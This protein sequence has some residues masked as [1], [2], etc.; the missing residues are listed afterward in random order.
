[1]GAAAGVNLLLGMVRVKFVAILIGTAGTGLLASFTS[2]QTLVTNICGF[3]V[4]SSA[5]RTLAAA[6]ALEDEDAI[7]RAALALHR[8]SWVTGL[9]GMAALAALSPLISDVTFRS[10]QYAPEIGA[11]GLVVLFTNLSGAQMALIQGMRR[12]GDIARVNLLAALCGTVNA[13][14]LYAAFGMRGIVPALIS[15]AAFQLA[16]S[17]H[18]ARRVPIAKVIVPWS[19][20]IRDAGG[21]VRLG[22]VFMWTG[23][24]ASGVNYVT[25]TFIT[26]QFGLHGAGLFSA[27]FALSGVVINFI[28]AAMG[29]DYYPRLTGA[30][31]ESALFR[32]LVNEQTEVGVLL[33]LPGLIATMTLAPWVIR[34]FYTSEFV[35]AVTLLHW[36]ILGCFGRVVAWPLGF[37]MPALGKDKWFLISETGGHLL[38]LALVLAGL[39]LFG[40]TGVAVAFFVVYL[41]YTIAVLSIA[42]HLVGFRWSRESALLIAYSCATLLGCFIA[43]NVLDLWPATLAGIAATLA[44]SVHNLRQLA[45]RL[46]PDHRLA[47]IARSVLAAVRVRGCNG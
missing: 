6:V 36:F 4:Q 27:G 21:M 35:P 45:K 5:V 17:W 1:M 46:E 28:L 29:A 32:Q 2:V 11:L 39:H 24:L 40:L 15:A 34:L 7:A 33:A 12:I 10:G 31:H 22:L 30:A 18:F 43:V 37:V 16:F 25:V 14:V 8:L 9:V 41:A 42:R 20:S 3:G 26:Q 38:H 19:E 47:R 23:L 44:V 13:V